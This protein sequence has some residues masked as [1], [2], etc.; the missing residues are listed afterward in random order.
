MSVKARIERLE[1][2]T[3]ADGVIHFIWDNDGE[4]REQAWSRMNPA[5]PYPADDEERLVFIMWR[6]V[7]LA[8]RSRGAA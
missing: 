4:T 6:G 5:E 2:E 3:G 1:R 8:E 7:E